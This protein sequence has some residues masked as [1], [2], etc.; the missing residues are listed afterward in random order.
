MSQEKIHRLLHFPFE[1]PAHAE[2]PPLAGSPEAPI[3]TLFTMLI[4]AIGPDGR[5]STATGNL[6]G[7]FGLRQQLLGVGNPQ[8]GKDV[9]AAVK[10][11]SLFSH[12]H[13]R[14]RALESDF[15]LIFSCPH[16]R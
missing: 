8:V 6:P 10:Y 7:K 4:T 1:P 5:K 14:I 11:F 9:A 2:F 16:S 15:N 13:F 12:G 3:L